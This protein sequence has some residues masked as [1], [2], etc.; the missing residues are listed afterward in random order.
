MPPGSRHDETG[1]LNEERGQL[2]L[3][4]DAGGTWRLDAPASAHK[5]KGMRV[6][7]IGTRAGFDL[8]DVEAVLAIA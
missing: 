6:R 8:L 7:I 1:W 5:L 4:R 3:C 2:I